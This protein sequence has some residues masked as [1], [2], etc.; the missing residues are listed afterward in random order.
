MR[1]SARDGRKGDKL[2]IRWLGPYEVHE[3]VG[4]GVYKLKNLSS[5]KVLKKTYNSCRCTFILCVRNLLLN[6]MYRLKVFR[7]RALPDIKLTVDNSIFQLYSSS[8]G[9]SVEDSQELGT[10]QSK[11]SHY[12]TIVHYVR[13]STM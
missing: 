4:K 10:V 2:A 1:N 3:H 13:C 11:I 12:D 7:T 6:Y 8:D 5:K 9:C